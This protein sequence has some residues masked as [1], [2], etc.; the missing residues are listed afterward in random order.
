MKITSTNP[1]KN[2]AA[3]DEIEF[4]T[5]EEIKK[6]VLAA[7]VVKKHWRS[8]GLE[9]RIKLIQPIIKRFRDNKEKIA[10]LITEETGKPIVQARSEVD[11]YTVH[12]QW[13]LDNAKTAL[14]DEITLDDETS[15]HKIVYEPYGVVAAIA[16]WNYPYGMA[17]WGIIPNLVV[18]NVVVFKTSE[19]CPLVG[20]LIDSLIGDSLPVG[21]FSEVYGD[22]EVGDMLTDQEIDYIWF[23]GSTNTGRQLYK[24]AAEK[25]IRVTLEMGGS[26]PCVIFEDANIEVAARN[27]FS[28]RF[29]HCGQVCTS[30]KRAIVHE[31]I[32]DEVIRMLKNEMASQ[33]IGDPESENTTISS[34]V[35]QRQ[36]E[37][38]QAQL[39]DAI[40]KGAKVVAQK[41]VPTQLKGAFFSPTLLTNITSEM[42]VWN[43][44][45]FGPILPVVSFKSEQE[46][47][48][49][50]NDTRYGLN[51]RIMSSDIERAE[52]VSSQI[53]AGG[54]KINTESS[55]TAADP[56]GGYKLSGIGREHGLLGLRELCQVKVIAKEK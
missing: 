24:K 51:A 21:V 41:G 1:A 19:E 18:G 27:L 22:G 54:I 15:I 14:N 2:F 29:A 38:L 46:A 25:F 56:F 50:A 32:F 23:T 40:S 42:R 7:H 34:L 43:E 44:E 49:L 4:T 8:I 26:S 39:D 10:Q 12:A 55:F 30:L 33:V 5:E 35:A 9:S 6:A 45:V 20:K 36:V 37:L 31:S 48:D 52:R 13:Y 11:C 28:M 47:I 3:I 17:I 53:E 16:P